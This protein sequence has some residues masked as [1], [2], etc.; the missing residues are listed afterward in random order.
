M[1]IVLGLVLLLMVFT[2]MQ[3]HTNVP[4]PDAQLTSLPQPDDPVEILQA[5]FS[6]ERPFNGVP[7]ETALERISAKANLQIFID[8]A[9]FKMFDPNQ[10]PEQL[11]TS[12]P[13]FRGLPL[14]SALKLLLDPI[15]AS[16]LV[17]ENHLLVVPRDVVYDVA[18]VVR[19]ERSLWQDM[20]HLDV[21]NKPV[22]TIASEVAKQARLNVVIAEEA[23]SRADKEVTVSFHNVGGHVALRMLAEM[24]GLKVIRDGNVYLLTTP[25]NAA[26]WKNPHPE[27]DFPQLDLNG[28]LG[29][30]GLPP[31]M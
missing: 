4:M 14:R 8:H 17:C 29:D 12:L 7:L 6:N 1:R 27:E 21:M 23:K 25:K 5:P 26:E 11:P 16:Y 15:N 31:L 2:P 24:V 9:A 18:R 13:R 20:V 10:T 22:R 28:G 3:V 19:K 30:L